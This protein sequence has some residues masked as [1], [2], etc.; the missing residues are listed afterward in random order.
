MT[1]RGGH[2]EAARAMPRSQAGG[3]KA[4]F[5]EVNRIRSRCR[6]EC[7]GSVSEQRSLEDWMWDPRA[8]GSSLFTTETWG[9][10]Q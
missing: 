3:W 2:R 6:G 10:R 8:Q 4:D 1:P 9:E 5:T 7:E